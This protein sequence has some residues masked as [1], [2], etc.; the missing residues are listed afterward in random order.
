VPDQVFDSALGASY[1]LEERIGSGATGEVWR[2]THRR[3]GQVIAAKILHRE[4]LEDDTLVERF[5][6]ERSILVAL[7]HPNVVAVRDLIVERHRLAIVMEHMGGG[8]LGETLR[9]HGPLRPAVALGAVAA[10]LD[11]LAAAHDRKVLH[12]DVKADNVLLAPAW[13]C[14][15]PGAVKLSDFG[16]A[17]I[18]SH[19]TRSSAGIVGTP[20]YLAPEQL[21]TGAGDLASDV[22][23]A[24]ILLYELLAGRTPFAGP[25]TGYALAYRHVTSEPPRLPVPAPVWDTVAGL[26][27]KDPA[28]R[29]TARVAAAQLRQLA[30][31]LSHLEALPVQGVAVHLQS[32]RGPATEVRGLVAPEPLSTATA[33]AASPSWPRHLLGRSGLRRSATGSEHGA[34]RSTRSTPRT[35]DRG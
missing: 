2:G 18:L 11:G 34:D 14:F 29:P 4:H 16:I 15:G 5:V 17:E 32:A 27:A 6:R 23:S 7:R 26:L 22:Y 12:R 31:A 33:S 35:R 10:V 24:G 30:P 25:E 28:R 19:D 13:Q 1:V 20:E 8:S 9:E 3:S 21:V